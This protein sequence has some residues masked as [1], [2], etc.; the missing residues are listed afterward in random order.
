MRRLAASLSTFAAIQL[1]V[2]VA[3][4]AACRHWPAFW[5]NEYRRIEDARDRR[6][7]GLA[8]P[9][10][11]L[12]GGSN[13]AFSIDSD[14]V[15]R[16]TGRH[17]VNLGLDLDLGLA[18]ILRRGAAAARAGDL[19]IAIP[20]YH[21]FFTDQTNQTL[22]TY[23]VCRPSDIR[24]VA[25]SQLAPLL[26]SGLLTMRDLARGAVASLRSPAMRE[27]YR[28]ELFRPN[29]DYIGHHGRPAPG[30]DPDAAPPPRAAELEIDRALDLLNRFA[31]ACRSTGAKPAFAFAPTTRGR[32]RRFGTAYRRVAAA[33][34]RGL[35][36]PVLDRLEGAIYRDADAFDA[37]Y[38]LDADAA[39]RRSR[40]LAVAITRRFG[41][42]R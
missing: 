29:G 13:V 14:E 9:R 31:S 11:L 20:E 8:P 34:E 39:R 27:A 5:G 23:L 24:H 17:V 10:L 30:F 19:V 21:H 42:R 36:M 28:A 32:M 7:A 25:P 18:F 15:E 4:A 22:L 3:L 1:L 2:L 6:L 38:H 16:I 33:A 35:D 41:R 12:L 37:E 40:A 26:D